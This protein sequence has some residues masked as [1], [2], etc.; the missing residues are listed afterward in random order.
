MSESE[1]AVVDEDDSSGARKIV[2][3]RPK[4]IK[5][6]GSPRRRLNTHSGLPESKELKK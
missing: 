2:Q 5:L 1:G 6:K 4:I 3:D